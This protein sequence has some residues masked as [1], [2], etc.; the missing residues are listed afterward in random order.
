VFVL[1][2][3]NRLSVIAS[4]TLPARDSRLTGR[5]PGLEEGFFKL[6]RKITVAAFHGAG[7]NEKLR[8]AFIMRVRF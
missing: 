6:G 8:V 4:V 5:S 1:Y 3:C 7:N 2:F